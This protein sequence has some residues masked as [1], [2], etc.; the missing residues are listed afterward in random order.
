LESLSI[1]PHFTDTRNRA[2]CGAR[3]GGLFWCRYGGVQS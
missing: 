2:R 3:D 1:I